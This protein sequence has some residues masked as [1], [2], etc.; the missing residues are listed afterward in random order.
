MR[1][2]TRR[3]LAGGA[4]LLTLAAVGGGAALAADKAETYKLSTNLVVGQEVPKPTGGSGS[5]TFS[6]TLTSGGQLK[7]T[8]TFKGLSGPALQAHIHLGKKGKPGAVI[9]PLCG[10]CTSPVKGTAQAQEGPGGGHRERRHV[11]QRPHHEER[12]RGDPRAARLEGQLSQVSA[13]R[14]R[15]ASRGA[16][17]WAARPRGAPA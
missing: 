13:P 3:W 2:S 15:A 17:S 12:C 7:Y 1:R 16:G 8:L 9:V 14:S 6:G 11:R 4:G 10:P 5:G